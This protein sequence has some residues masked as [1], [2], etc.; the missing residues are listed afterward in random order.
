[1]DQKQGTGMDEK[2]K[3]H[4]F[5]EGAVSSELVFKL[6]Q[7]YSMNTAIGAYSIFIG[8]VRNDHAGDARVSA[9]EFTTIP[10]MAHEKF[11][12]IQADLFAKHDLISLNVYHSQGTVKTGDICFLVLAASKHRAAAISACSEAVERVKSQVPIWGKM[13]LENGSVQWKE[14]N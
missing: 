10:D 1:M 14:N 9:V 7:Q 8:Q 6:L 13:I 4:I 12:E 5:I 11:L 3:D 2:I